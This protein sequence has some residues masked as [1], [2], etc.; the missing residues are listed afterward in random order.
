M[1]GGAF[2]TT[3]MRNLS[4]AYAAALLIALTTACGGSGG[5]NG[6]T[7]PP[8]NNTATVGIVVVTPSSQTIA[9]GQ[10]ATFT[11]EAR[12]SAGVVIAGK[13]FAWA[14]SNNA[15]ATV[16]NGVVTAVSAGGALIT[17]TVDGV[18]G[19]ASITVTAL[20]VNRLTITPTPISLVVGQTST[21]TVTTYNGT[22][23]LTGRAVAYSSNNS[24]VA[25]VSTSG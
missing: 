20:A 23:V 22:T 18:S 17:A 16:A 4:S 13:S 8:P 1:R 24:T 9:Q 7:N 21:L 15:V 5:S 11:A 25:S 6:P 2:P 10:T 3:Q 12:T 14:S 19:N